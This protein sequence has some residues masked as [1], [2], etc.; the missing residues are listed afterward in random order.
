M[1]D[2][3]I[4]SMRY[5]DN[6]TVQPRNERTLVRFGRN[7]RWTNIWAQRDGTLQWC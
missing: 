4:E 6:V 5:S 1:G 3:V 7:F 2:I